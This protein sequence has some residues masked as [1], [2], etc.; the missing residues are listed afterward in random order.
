MTPKEKAIDLLKK[1]FRIY[2]SF[3]LNKFGALQAVTEMKD[4]FSKDVKFKEE[5]L[6]WEEVQ[7]EIEL[8]SKEVIPPENKEA[9]ADKFN[10]DLY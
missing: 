8:K 1:Y 7:Y 4:F 3:P 2:E 10:E 5:F 9:R 6:Y